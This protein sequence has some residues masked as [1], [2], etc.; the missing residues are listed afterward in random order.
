[1]VANQN[2]EL[3]LPSKQLKKELL[4]YHGFHAQAHNGNIWYM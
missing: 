2:T 3:V 4:E 1:M